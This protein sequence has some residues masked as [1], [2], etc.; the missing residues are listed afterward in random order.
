MCD[1]PEFYRFSEPVAR[2]NHR[3][4]DCGRRVEIGQKHLAWSG[5]SDGDVFTAR[6]CKQCDVLRGMLEK[7]GFGGD[8]GCGIAWGGSNNCNELSLEVLALSPPKWLR[9]REAAIR[10]RVKYY[11]EKYKGY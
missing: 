8:D 11:G 9:E 3:C 10:H 5:K 1:Y 4:D 6:S 7:E 2:K